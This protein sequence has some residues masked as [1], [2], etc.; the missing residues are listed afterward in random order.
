VVEPEEP[1]Y[2]AWWWTGVYAANLLLPLT[3]GV[4][5]TTGKG[6]GVVGMLGAVVVGWLVGLAGCFHLPRATEAVTVGGMYVAM[7]Q[8]LP[9]LHLAAGLLALVAW[10]KVSGGVGGG[11]PFQPPGW[12]AELGG[13]G[14][15]VLTA[16]PLL[17]LAWVLGRG[18]RLL[19][20]PAVARTAEEADYIEP[21]PA[22]RPG[23]N[24]PE[25]S[26]DP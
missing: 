8:L 16:V 2:L 22:D 18:P 24:G 3:I 11:S 10:V 26:R 5:M 25:P 23:A 12:R 7:F 15:A 19:F 14:V 1:Q 17:L 21:E 9:V 20:A 6:G 4:L 13:F